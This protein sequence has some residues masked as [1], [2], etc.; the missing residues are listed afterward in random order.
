MVCSKTSHSDTKFAG[1]SVILLLNLDTKFA[2]S[3]T[4]E[5][6]QSRLDEIGGGGDLLS[7]EVPHCTSTSTTI[8][9]DYD[10]RT[11]D[12]RPPDN[13]NF[14]Q[15]NCVCL[16]FLTV[17]HLLGNTRTLWTIMCSHTNRFREHLASPY[18]RISVFWGISE[19]LNLTWA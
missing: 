15:Q 5:G 17:Q 9:N 6:D 8:W 7:L 13:R 16:L 10:M 2:G 19:K 14:R 3:Y 11:A 1:L 18:F 4:Y 12:P